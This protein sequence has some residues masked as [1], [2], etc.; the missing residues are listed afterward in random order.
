MTAVKSGAS[1]LLAGVLAAAWACG[2]KPAAPVETPP[3]P[4]ADL[5][6]LLPDAD[7]TTG[8]A[9]VSTPSGTVDLGAAREYTQVANAKAPAPVVVMSE[10]EVARQFGDVLSTLPPPAE[11]F[12]LNFRFESDELTPESKAL[13][14][15]ILAA[16]RNRPVPEVAVIGHTDTTGTP[17]GNFTLG[18]KR[19]QMVRG[20]L[21]AE[22]LTPTLV[23]A[24]S[25][26]EGDLLV[27]TADGV[28][29][30]RN[31]RV[32]ITIR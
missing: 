18:L 9:I 30:P 32:E 19:A 22:G 23:V 20:L 5:I 29:E 15:P 13:V 21:V 8:R 31:R 17:E 11:H 24:T 27:P 25:H 6:L 1:A 12:T 28:L 16:V 26:G 14:G 3:P 7:G 4:R 10:A 2:P